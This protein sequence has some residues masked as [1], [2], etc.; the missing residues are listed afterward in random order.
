MPPGRAYI[1]VK[2]NRFTSKQLTLCK[3]LIAIGIPPSVTHPEEPLR[4]SSA[5]LSTA[6]A[7]IHLII[8]LFRDVEEMFV[9][10][11][12]NLNTKKM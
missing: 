11:V 9:C 3:S 2:S 4:A 5:Y 8:A 7:L 10:Q 12:L 6:P 1:S